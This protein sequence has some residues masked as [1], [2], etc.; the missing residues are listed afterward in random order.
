MID[1]E[2]VSEINN[3]LMVEFRLSSKLKW[4]KINEG[5]TNENYTIKKSNGSPL[6]V[7]KI[8]TDDEIYLP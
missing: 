5:Y 8:F 4:E 3:Y 1:V 6:A 7:C 2:L